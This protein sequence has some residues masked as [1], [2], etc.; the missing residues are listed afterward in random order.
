MVNRRRFLGSLAALGGEFRPLG[1]IA[2]EAGEPSRTA[3]GAALHRAAHQ[4]LE[5]P[6]VFDDP[7][8]LQILGGQRVRWLANNL[9]RDP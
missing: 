8:A 3:Q 9:A 4:L 1:A 5:R 6:L 2:L 7:L